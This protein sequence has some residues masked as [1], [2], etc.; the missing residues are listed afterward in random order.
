[1]R[2]APV[3]ISVRIP[4]IFLSATI[5]SLGHLI[6]TGMEESLCI[7]DEQAT[8]D[9]RVSIDASLGGM[10]GRSMMLKYRFLPTG[11]THV[12]PRLP[13]PSVWLSAMI[14]VPSRCPFAAS[15]AAAVFVEPVTGKKRISL[16]IVTF[17]PER[18]FLISSMESSG[19]LMFFLSVQCFFGPPAYGI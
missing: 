19:R 2:S 15:S 4:P 5:K 8:A 9:I 17:R 10:Q 1:M 16:P 6:D 14:T 7:A 13:L 3:F 12:L 11:D 18:P